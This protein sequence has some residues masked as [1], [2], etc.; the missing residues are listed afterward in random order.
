MVGRCGELIDFDG[1]GDRVPAEMLDSGEWALRVQFYS[2]DSA[3]LCADTLHGHILD[4]S[5]PTVVR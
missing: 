2:R 4:V 3:L 1:A 5:I